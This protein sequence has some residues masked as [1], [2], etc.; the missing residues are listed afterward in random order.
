MRSIAFIFLLCSFTFISGDGKVKFNPLSSGLNSNVMSQRQDIIHSKKAF[1]ALWTQLHK[2]DVMMGDLPPEVDFSKR[3][4]VVCYIGDQSNGLRI[5][6]V[7]SK[8]DTLTVYERNEEFEADCVDA[9]L[10]VTPFQIIAVDGAK[11]A[12]A[13]A[14]VKV[15]N[16]EC[17]D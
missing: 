11:W 7:K 12:K 1:T 10:L 5:D 14:V 13:S 3:S 9:K 2:T 17:A 4:V 8:G 6:S 15:E 16:V